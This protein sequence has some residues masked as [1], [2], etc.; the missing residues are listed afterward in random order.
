MTRPMTV[1]LQRSVSDVLS[2]LKM[3]KPFGVELG[4]VGVPPS[5]AS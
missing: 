1:A 5:P 4:M 3:D 2:E